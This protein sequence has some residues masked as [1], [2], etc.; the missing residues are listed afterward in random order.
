M[1]TLAKLIER[2]KNEEDQV[3]KA[4]YGI[5]HRQEFFNAEKGVEYRM[6]KVPTVY[7]IEQVPA[8]IKYRYKLHAQGYVKNERGQVEQLWEHMF[9]LYVLRS[10]PFPLAT[11]R[12]GAPIRIVW[13]TPI[14]HPNIAPGVDYGGSG[15]VCW[16]AFIKWTA[17]INMLNIVEG[18]KQL[19]ENPEP[20]D[21]IRNPPICLEAA[22]YFKKRP[23]PKVVTKRKTNSGQ[24]IQ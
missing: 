2:L 10:Y 11:S 18:V 22:E 9:D 14:F 13:I 21:P 4:G 15:V 23:P 24:A 5:V 20:N 3:R 19:I 12:L 8:V 16:R 6:V 1:L 17:M 7:G